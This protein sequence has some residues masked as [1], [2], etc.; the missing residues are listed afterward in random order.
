MLKDEGTTIVNINFLTRDNVLK[1][2]LKNS[3]KVDRKTLNLLRNHEIQAI[4][5]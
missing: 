1:I 4:I 2:R 5:R 3:R